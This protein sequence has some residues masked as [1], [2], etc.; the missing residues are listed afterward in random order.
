MRK[1]LRHKNLEDLPLPLFVSAT[2]FI[3][4]RQCIFSKGNIVDAV[5]A[6]SSIPGLFQPVFID[7]VPYVDGGLYNNLPVEPFQDEKQNVIAVYVN[8][9]APFNKTSSMAQTLDRSF[10]L[11]F[12]HTVRQ[13]AEGCKMYIE[14]PELCQFGLFEVPK[15]AAIYTVGYE[16]ARKMMGDMRYEI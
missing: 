1:N 6:A 4:G 13:S 14:P 10:H 16:Y 12:A 8:P 3:D 2:N 7:E 15:L 5:L 11:S 9:I